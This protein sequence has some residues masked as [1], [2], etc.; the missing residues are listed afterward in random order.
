[1]LGPTSPSTLSAPT[2]SACS[3]G[4]RSSLGAVEG[5]VGGGPSPKRSPPSP[6]PFALKSVSSRGLGPTVFVAASMTAGF[7]EESGATAPPIVFC[8]GLTKGMY[9]GA[10]VAW[11]ASE[12]R[13]E[14]RKMDAKRSSTWRD[15]TY[16]FGRS[17]VSAVAEGRSVSD[18]TQRMAGARH[19][20]RG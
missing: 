10:N 3:P 6:P 19:C 14:I 5:A 16:A 12:Q 13:R 17:S 2:C 15:E 9:S 18:Y 7:W 8:P 11:A 4:S 1:M 20:R